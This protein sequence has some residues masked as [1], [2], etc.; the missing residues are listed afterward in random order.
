LIFGCFN[1][2][3]FNFYLS[4]NYQKHILAIFKPMKFK[5]LV[6]NQYLHDFNH[7]N[8]LFDANICIYSLN[9]I[10]LLN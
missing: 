7:K 1:C 5:I 8:L 6:K 10:Y 9:T 4:E 2:E 3:L